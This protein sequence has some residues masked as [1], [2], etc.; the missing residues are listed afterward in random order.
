MP[1]AYFD[2]DGICY[3]VSDIPLAVAP[4]G[5]AIPVER[6]LDPNAVWFDGDEVIHCEAMPF[7]IPAARDVEEGDF[8]MPL[9]DGVIAI[10]DGERQRGTLT[11]PARE[12]RTVSVLI[13]GKMTGDAIVTIHT[14]A[15]QRREAY[16]PIGDQLDAIWKAL[17]SGSTPD[18][19]AD[20]EAVKAAYP[21]P[22]EST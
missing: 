3:A 2:P 17:A 10:V 4:N 9:P 18:M 20:I 6:G 19:L 1:L 14:Y 8:T 12:E 22:D 13:R 11:V 21:K 15:S 16:P 7:A 5:A